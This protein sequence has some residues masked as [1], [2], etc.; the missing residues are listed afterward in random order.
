[1][2]VG[3]VESWPQGVVP[4]WYTSLLP[5][6]I[7]LKLRG[8]MLETKM[9]LLTCVK[10]IIDCRWSICSKSLWA[11]SFITLSPTPNL[12]DPCYPKSIPM[13]PTPSPSRCSTPRSST[14][15][16]H[17]TSHIPQ[18]AFAPSASQLFVGQTS[19]STAL[20][21]TRHVMRPQRR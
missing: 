21:K 7:A 19:R 12:M 20:S 2:S 13:P 15:P 9:Y 10:V 18:S 11:L 3:D 1:M 16:A 4:E 14:L 17:P 6:H 5:D 8:H